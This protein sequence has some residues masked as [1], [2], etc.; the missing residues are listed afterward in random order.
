MHNRSI[1]ILLLTTVLTFSTLYVPQ[2]ILPL[3]AEDFSVSGSEISLLISLTLFPLGLTPIVYGYL[4]DNISARTILHWFIGILA[5]TELSLAFVMDFRIMLG[6]RLLQGLLLPAIFTAIVTYISNLSAAHQRQKS[7]SRYI[8]ATITGGFA[9]RFITGLISDFSDWRTAFIVWSI[10]LLIAWSLLWKLQ[11]DIPAQCNSL[12]ISGIWQMFKRP[13]H[14][15]VYLTVSIVFFGFA[16][17]LNVLPFRIKDISPE[18]TESL[19]ASAYMGYLMGVLVSLNAQRIC[20]RLGSEINS[21][22]LGILTFGVGFLLFTSTNLII[23]IF[24]VFIF[25]TGFFLMHSTLSAYIN[26]HTQSQRGVANGLYISFYYTGGSLGSYFPLI[27]YHNWGWYPYL[28]LVII[29][30]M[31]GLSIVLGLNEAEKKLNEQV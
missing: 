21:T 11:K 13:L 30:T 17:A 2:P 7:V 22:I 14:F 19:I 9:G 8:A 6:L 1:N 29:S 3:L 27:I 24:A 28:I 15:R 4:I 25:S 10:G 26:H 16:S 31:L 5:V 12:E 18:A 23:I 20:A